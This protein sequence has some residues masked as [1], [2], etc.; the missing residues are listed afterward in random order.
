MKQKIII[1]AKSMSQG[2]QIRNILDKNN[3]TY[4][5][6]NKAINRKTGMVDYRLMAFWVIKT[7][8]PELL[9]DKKESKKFISIL[10][11]KAIITGTITIYR[12]RYETKRYGNSFNYKRRKKAYMQLRTFKN[13]CKEFINKKINT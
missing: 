11:K 7:E 13:G 3:I 4:R 6:R 10:E 1:D 8:F 12:N 5:V 9:A 2:I